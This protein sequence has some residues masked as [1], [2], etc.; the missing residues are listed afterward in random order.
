MHVN[1]QI[2]GEGSGNVLAN[3]PCWSFILG[4]LGGIKSWGFG[5]FPDLF[6]LMMSYDF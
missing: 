3:C 1:L 2:I 6:V 5:V 4:Q